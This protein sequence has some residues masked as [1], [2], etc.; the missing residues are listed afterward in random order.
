MKKGCSGSSK[1]VLVDT[2]N[3]HYN[4][5]LK[6]RLNSAICLGTSYRENKQMKQIKKQSTRR[7]NKMRISCKVESW[8]WPN[9]RLTEHLHYYNHSKK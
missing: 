6:K 9:D 3:Q 4:I 1:I 8:S 7:L 5:E 2:R